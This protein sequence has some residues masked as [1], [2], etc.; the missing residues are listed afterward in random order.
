VKVLE[1]LGAEK[2]YGFGI[3]GSGKSSGSG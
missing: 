2:T 1:F 3:Y